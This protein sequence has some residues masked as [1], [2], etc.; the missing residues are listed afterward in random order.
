M[1]EWEGIVG[2]GEEQVWGDG[3]NQPQK[4]IGVVSA[5]QVVTPIIPED[6]RATKSRARRVAVLCGLDYAFNWQQWVNRSN[7]GEVLEYLFGSQS[8]AGSDPYTHTYAYVTTSLGLP[9]FTLFV[10]R[11]IGA[12]PADA[13][14][15]CVMNQVVF[16]NSAADILMATCEGVGRERSQEAAISLTSADCTRLGLDPFKFS[17]LTFKKGIDGAALVTDT[18]PERLSIT[19]TNNIVTDKRSADQSLYIQ[20]PK[21]GIFEVTG[22]YDIEFEDYEEYDALVANQQLDVEAT[23]SDGT[24]SLLLRVPNARITASPLGSIG[25]TSDRSMVT[26]E[27]SGL[28]DCDSSEVAHAVLVNDEAAI[29]ASWSSS[30]SSQSSSSSSSS[31]STQ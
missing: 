26:I 8:S 28:Y 22:A 18:T 13:L 17:Q 2:V 31:S 5:E 14:M 25:G 11:G 12:N 23:W 6:N 24:Y 27:F 3:L 30:S 9:G 20:R 1:M 15:G 4:L 7:I 10:D 21:A 16:E 19:I 29:P